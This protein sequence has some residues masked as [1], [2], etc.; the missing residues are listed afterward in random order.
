MTSSQ[1]RP[2]AA[3]RAGLTPIVCVGET[4][5]ERD[6]G[7]DRRS[8][9]APARRGAGCAGARRRG[10]VGAGLR[11]G[12]GDRHRPDGGA[13]AGAGS[14]RVRCGRGCV[15]A[16]AKDVPL[17]YGGSVKAGNAAALFAMADIDGGLIGGA[18][19]EATEFLAIA[20]A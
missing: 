19:L 1:R 5:A 15:A 18:S 12:V 10:A 20:A 8:G 14:A 6:A 9:A 3:M 7:H 2:S 13:R 17:L 16:G 4:L 11:A